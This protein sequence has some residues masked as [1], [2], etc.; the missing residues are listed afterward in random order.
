MTG[1]E[2]NAEEPKD[3]VPPEVLDAALTRMRNAA[4]GNGIDP[5]TIAMT[6]F[7][8]EVLHFTARNIV[9]VK[10]TL[11]EKSVP[12]RES[13]GEVCASAADLRARIQ[14]CIEKSQYDPAVITLLSDLL[15]K[16]P[17]KGFA[18]NDLTFKLD[19][20]NT[21]FVYYNSC[22]SCT[23]GKINCMSCQ[24]QGRTNCAKCQ[25]TRLIKCPDCRGQKFIRTPQGQNAPCRKCAG[26]GDVQC[27]FC[28]GQGTLPCKPC[29]ATG[30]V[31]CQRCAG[32]GIISDI[33]YVSFEGKTH[34]VFDEED[35]PP[36][37]AELILKLGPELVSGDHVAAEILREKEHDAAQE[38]YNT[39]DQS[40]RR[41]ELVV[42]YLIDLPYGQIGFTIGGGDEMRGLL[43]GLH[44]RLL[45]LPPFLE[46]PLAPGLDRLQQAAAHAGNAR[47]DLN[48][49]IRFR[50]IGDALIAAASLPPKKAARLL[51]K[52]WSLGLRRE[53]TDQMVL[54]A[55]RA[56]ANITRLP[57]L[58]GLG[59]GMALAGGL[60]ALWLGAGRE[61]VPPL[62]FPPYTLYGVDLLVWLCGVFIA[63]STARISTAYAVRNLFSRLLPPEK[64]RKL[65]PQLPQIVSIAVLLGG[66]A[67]FFALTL[68]TAQMPF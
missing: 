52:K 2:D 54:T 47:R 56:F 22:T 44:P 15:D 24:G 9:E 43:F 60:Y 58:A 53:T 59:A 10:P 48:E 39:N 3:P 31:D 25:G 26:R 28:R 21:V 65:V 46:G 11:V 51:H 34:C 35:L 17:D 20:M 64:A 27:A 16:R 8:G 40:S 68:F 49:A 42:P 4:R 45:N 12:G 57:R 1:E 14:Q 6:F 37:V 32:S 5:D 50:A 29:A 23:G 66:G 18:V 61:A 33:G 41:N 13:K 55:G 36:G 62:P 19:S 7:D 30:R 63:L 67:L 38:T